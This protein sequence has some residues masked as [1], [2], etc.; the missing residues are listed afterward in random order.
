MNNSRKT[1]NT[2]SHP[3]QRFDKPC[4]NPFGPVVGN[5]QHIIT[6]NYRN[7]RGEVYVASKALCFRRTALFGWEIFRLVVPWE[8]VKAIDVGD[9]RAIFIQTSND[10]QHEICG[11]H[12]DDDVSVVRNLLS[13][14]WNRRD[15]ETEQDAENNRVVNHFFKRVSLLS[16]SEDVCEGNAAA[17]KGTLEV[18]K[19]DY[20]DT[21]TKDQ[22]KNLWSIICSEKDSRLTEKVTVVSF[23]LPYTIS[24]C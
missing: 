21:M 14:A 23:S 20:Q 7:R 10:E 13:D 3:K 4:W 22:L 9:F 16:D 6:C 2:S 5:M 15:V 8:S 11:F 18:V 12:D 1:A 17:E 24:C 19:G